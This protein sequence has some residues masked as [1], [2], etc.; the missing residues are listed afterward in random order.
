MKRL[1]P[2]LLLLAT[3]PV[4][5]DVTHTLQSVVSLKVEQANSVS[6]RVG[7]TISAQGTNVTPS[8][9]SVANAIGSLDLSDSGITSGVPTVDYDTSFSVT[10]AGD[11]WSVQ[12]TYIQAD[13][14]PALLST[15]VT[16]GVVPSLV[17]FGDQTVNSGGVAG[18]LAGA[19][20]SGHGSMSITAGGAGTTATLQTTSTIEID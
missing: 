4:R 19:L 14:I 8:A 2:I 9:N 18:S 7:S 5:A 1:I 3:N 12:E 15:T 11:N 13:A 16:S 20:D 17:T 6:N 10:N